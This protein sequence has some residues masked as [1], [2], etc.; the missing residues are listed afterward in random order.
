[1]DKQNVVYLYNEILSTL[2]EEWSSNIC[3]NTDEPW[4]HYA[5]WKKLV[6][7]DH[8]L[9]ESIYMRCTWSRLVAT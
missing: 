9:Y 4:K 1:M 3:Y 8:I 7:K 5:K 6:T 2:K